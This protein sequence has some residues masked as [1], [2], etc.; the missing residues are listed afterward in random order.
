VPATG[1]AP[2]Q[3]SHPATGFAPTQ[4]S[5][6]A[7][8]LGGAAAQFA[9]PSVHTGQSRKPRRT[10]LIPG[11]IVSV[12]GIGGAAT[13]VAVS[14]GSEVASSQAAAESDAQPALISIDAS[15]AAVAAE[16]IVADAALPLE[17]VEPSET[18]TDRP[19]DKKDTRKNKGEPKPPKSA[20]DLVAEA[21]S[22]ALASQYRK[23]WKL[24][25]KALLL[26]PGNKQ[27]A[28]VCAVAACKLKKKTVAKRHYR[29][30]GGQKRALVRHTC[31]KSG[32]ELG[33]AE[34]SDG[35]D[36]RPPPSTL[37]KMAIKRVLAR[38][39]PRLKACADTHPFTGTLAVQATILASG[40]ITRVVAR[41]G[42]GGLNRCV[43]NAM[44]TLR[45]P[46]ASGSTEL[47]YPFTFQ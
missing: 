38:I 27:A 14:P 5:H 2:T 17:S 35:N 46:R 10:W 30:L 9:N 24:C 32:V 13:F 45:F 7:T 29:V 1:F 34:G 21:K 15:S 23:S 12:L 20:A 8:T 6:P 39:R 25:K 3:A 33:T 42:P 22:A 37:N 31:L 16:V 40:K 47:R 26:E 28:M 43:K 44:M 19:K 11:L 4:A 18:K 36:T 41:G